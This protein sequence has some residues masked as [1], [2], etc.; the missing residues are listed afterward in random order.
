MSALLQQK[1][2]L[3]FLQD[4]VSSS[5]LLSTEID[6]SVALHSP[7]SAQRISD[8]SKLCMKHL[9]IDLKCTATSRHCYSRVKLYPC[10]THRM[11]YIK[12]HKCQTFLFLFSGCNQASSEHVIAW[13][14]LAL[15]MKSSTDIPSD[16]SWATM[17]AGIAAC[18]RCSVARGGKAPMWISAEASGEQEPTC[19]SSFRFLPRVVRAS[20]RV[21]PNG[22]SGPSSFHREFTPHQDGC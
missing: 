17:S 4:F 6:F 22:P 19:L 20:W 1:L 12:N 18:F 8:I 9:C 16:P 14:T 10:F 11:W 21:S 7:K 2:K 13:L 5:C 15:R 3:Y